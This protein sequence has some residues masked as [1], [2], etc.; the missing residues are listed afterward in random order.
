M[1]DR[2]AAGGVRVVYAGK[3]HK[4]APGKSRPS[5]A[6]G[7]AAVG[8][9]VLVLIVIAAIDADISGRNSATTASTYTS[10]S[11]PS[12]TAGSQ[13]LPGWGATPPTPSSTNSAVPPPRTAEPPAAT[14]A[15]QPY[16]NG[17]WLRNYWEGDQDCNS[18]G[19]YWVVQPGTDPG[20]Y[21]LKIGCFPQAWI[22][23]LNAHCQSFDLPK[24]NCAVWDRDGIM[25][26]FK[27]HGD[28]LIVV[29]TQACLD[30]A[31]LPDFHEG[32]LH[33]DCVKQP[34]T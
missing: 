15:A 19:S 21:A 29:L 14:G 24:G 3:V 30:R 4:P 11:V 5:P 23:N 34:S 28:L 9:V 13:N 16:W 2:P 26:V 31:G 27:K 6:L 20:M 22:N 10:P 25:S 33:Q 17:P 12:T 1:D 8:T 32:R 7:F 18:G